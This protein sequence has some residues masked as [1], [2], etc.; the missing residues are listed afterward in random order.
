MSEAS[1]S[2]VPANSGAHPL[3][4][5]RDASKRY[6][7]G[8]VRALDHVSMQI[9]AGEF[10]SIMGPS[11][12]GKSTLL[13]LIGA[14]DLPTEGEVLFR[15]EPISKIGNLDQ[16]RS[17]EIGFV[18]QSFYLLPNLTAEENVQLP[19]FESPLKPSQRVARARDLL[20]QVGLAER[21]R[22]FPEQ[23]SNGQKQRVA[24]ARALANS[25]TLVLA[26]EPTGALDSK[27]GSEVMQVLA[28]LNENQGMTLVV[29]THDQGVANRA[30]RIV[31]MI[32]GRLAE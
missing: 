16:L 18:F 3:I 1:Q 22:H 2:A 30:R 10:V 20:H 26:D 12:C 8:D 29:V 13:N 27:H 32:D 5:V 28:E 15:G 25:P 9:L 24:I 7:E 11:G 6:R 4:Q 17:R 21:L 14:L 19:M 31:H 23:L